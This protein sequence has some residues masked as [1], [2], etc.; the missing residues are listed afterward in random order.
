MKLVNF[1]IL[2]DT[3]L[4]HLAVGVGVPVFCYFTYTNPKLVEPDEGIYQLCYKETEE[5]DTF[6]LHKCSSDITITDLQT[7]FRSFKT[8]LE[9]KGI[10]L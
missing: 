7:C 8:K 5:L 1:A 2:P 6:G 3:G 4:Y 9:K 10:Y